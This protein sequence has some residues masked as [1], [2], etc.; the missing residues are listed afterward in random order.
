MSQNFTPYNLGFISQMKMHLFISTKWTF[1]YCAVP[2]FLGTAQTGGF[3]HGAKSG[4][5]CTRGLT[6]AAPNGAFGH[7][8]FSGTASTGN[9][10]GRK[11]LVILKH[12][13]HIFIF[14]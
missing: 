8:L 10:C 14:N 6:K 1:Y 9:V 4:N 11:I 2:H 5:L 12:Q 7:S 13:K 3:I